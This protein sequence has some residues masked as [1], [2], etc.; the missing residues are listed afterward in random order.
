MKRIYRIPGVD[1][2]I[3]RR[4]KA[5]RTELRITQKELAEAL[6]LA[7]QQIQKYETGINRMSAAVLYTLTVALDLPVAFFFAGFEAATHNG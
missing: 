1:E 3:G 4:L 5:R 7:P 6:G 2:H